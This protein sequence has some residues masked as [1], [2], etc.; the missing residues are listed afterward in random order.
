[1]ELRHL[2]M[3]REVAR[4]GNLT[5]AAA[6][7]YLSQSA[8]SHQLK[9]I[10]DFFN[11]QIF[12]RQK[13]Q[14]LL[15]QTGKIILEA[16]E[17]IVSELEQTTKQVQ[18]LT[19][20]NAGE[21]RISTECYTSYHW[22][23]G[24]LTEFK[25][26]YPKVDIQINP[27]AT[28]N[29]V[30][31]LL[32][33]KID[34]GIVEDNFNPRLAYTSLFRDEFMAIV[35]NDHPWAKLKWVSEEKFIDENYIMYNIPNEVSTVFAKL[36]PAKGPKKV[37]KIS[38]TEAIIQMVKAGMGVAVLPHWVVS[39]HIRS[40]E[41]SAISITRS[42][43]KRTWYAA[44][45]KNRVLPPYMNAFIRNLSRHLKSSEELSMRRMARA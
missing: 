17:R 3:I 18:F 28:Y 41:L 40:G 34:I 43:I 27:E 12:I 15:T 2:K 1:M 13:K 35:P 37:Y 24:F 45:L 8:L 9:E 23:S 6:C 21:I 25:H 16:S 36:F 20:K 38:L 11:T 7:L 14:M 5:K 10:E 42:G 19:E 22:L 32:E 31:S 33:N 4:Q 39:P 29:S 26:I 30:N 44:V